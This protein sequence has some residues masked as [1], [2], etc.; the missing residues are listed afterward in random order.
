VSD[1]RALFR[2]TSHY[3]AGQVAALALSF[4]SFPIFTRVLSVADYGIM[5]LVLQI[6]TMTVVVSKLGLGQSIQRF[7]P[8]QESSS[9]AGALHKFCSTVFYGATLCGI[10]VTVLF[11]VGL[12]IVPDSV[13][14]PSLRK[15]LLIGSGLVFVRGV[16]PILM[17]F[18]RAERRTKTFNVFN[19]VVK[20]ATIA[21][22]CLLFLMWRRDVNAVLAGTLIV[23]LVSVIVLVVVIL[24]RDTFSLS[25]FDYKLLRSA[26]AYGLPLALWEQAAIILDAGDRIFVQYYL[27]FEA[28]GYYSCACTITNYI[29]QSLMYPLNLAL[30]PIYMKMW[31]TQGREQT[32]VFLSKILNYFIMIVMCVLAG[33]LVT[34][35]SAVIVLGSAK[36]QDA[37]PLLPTLAVGVMLYAV[38]IFFSAGLV[39]HKKTKTLAKI[40]AYSAILNTALNVL[41]IPRIGLQG[42]ALATLISYAFF[43]AILV[44][45]SSAI[46][47]L[48]VNIAGCLR[49]LV[50]AGV[51]VVLTSFAHSSSPFLDFLLRG[52]LCVSIY[53]TMLLLIDQQFRAMTAKALPFLERILGNPEKEE[54]LTPVPTIDVHSKI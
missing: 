13:I 41:L 18:L 49:Y 17:N 19:T 21:F 16:Q 33:V 42:A 2:E 14:S 5:A 53:G 34:A 30:V 32:T 50:A 20:G 3:L 25:T 23:E 54:Q 22:I 29:A 40:I 35:R 37:A 27:N 28:L 10:S 43:L 52:T 7:Y 45:A 26:V 31:E 38:H 8:E 12:E 6:V 48:R 46:M 4:V 47:P 24:P 36:L 44:R 15:V 51:S 1:L 11:I 9:E 39:I